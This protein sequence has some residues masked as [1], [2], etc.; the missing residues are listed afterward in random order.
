MIYGRG[1]ILL[2]SSGKTDSQ[3]AESNLRDISSGMLRLL[4]WALQPR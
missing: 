1:N 4:K 2:C 3:L